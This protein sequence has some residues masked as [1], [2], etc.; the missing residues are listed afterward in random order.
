M[1]LKLA[2]IGTGL[3]WKRLHYPAIK[4][5]KDRYEIVAICNN[6]IEDAQNVAR[7]VGAVGR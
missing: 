7:Q 6:T 1:K 3:A 5:L 4:Q 2:I